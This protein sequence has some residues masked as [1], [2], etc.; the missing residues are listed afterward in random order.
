[1]RMPFEPTQV[2]DADI[3]IRTAG[4]SDRVVAARTNRRNR[5]HK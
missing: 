2:N 3:V 5:P 1:M 4:P